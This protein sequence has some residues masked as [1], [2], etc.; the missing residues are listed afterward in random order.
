[1]LG[2]GSQVVTG[3]KGLGPRGASASAHRFAKRSTFM[4]VH[5][6]PRK[7]AA[8]I[9]YPAR[10][11]SAFARPRPR[12]IECR[13]IRPPGHHR[14]FIRGLRCARRLTHLLTVPRDWT[15]PPEPRSLRRGH[16]SRDD[17]STGRWPLRKRDPRHQRDPASPRRCEEPPPA[18]SLE[19]R[20]HP[21]CVQPRSS[22][23]EK[24]SLRAPEGPEQPNRPRRARLQVPPVSVSNLPRRQ[25]AADSRRDERAALRRHPVLGPPRRH[26]GSSR[27]GLGRSSTSTMTQAR[28]ATSDRW[29]P[30][31]KSGRSR[32]S[33]CQSPAWSSSQAI[34]RRPT[35]SWQAS[36]ATIR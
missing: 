21:P 26:S 22:P 14:E 13:A 20:V 12:L 11:P 27:K 30:S 9:S 4:T 36:P 7:M 19:P 8:A 34:R 2:R 33:R 3:R 23:L 32:A 35:G 31:S 1:V 6:P 15:D 18:S 17:P 5:L 25:F 10:I 28:L 24:A 29:S 16:L